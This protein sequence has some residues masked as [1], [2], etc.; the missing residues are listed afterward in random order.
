MPFAY[1]EKEM[2]F[3]TFFQT[4]NHGDLDLIFNYN[5]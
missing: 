2:I 3:G 4:N 1:F 5:K